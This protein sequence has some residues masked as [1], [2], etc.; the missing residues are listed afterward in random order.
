MSYIDKPCSNCCQFLVTTGRDGII[1]YYR[2]DHVLTVVGF[3]VNICGSMVLIGLRF[4]AKGDMF[5]DVGD[6]HGLSKACV[7][8][9]FERFI[10]AVNNKLDNIRNKRHKDCFLQKKCKIPN[11]LGATDGTLI[12]I[13][14][15]KEHEETFVCRKG[16]HALNVQ[17]V[18]DQKMRFTDIVT[19]WPGS[20]HDAS[21]FDSCGLK[22]YLENG[23]IS[24]HLGD[25]GYPLRK[26]LIT[27]KLNPVT[28]AEMR[29]SRAHFNGRIIVERTFGVLKSRFRCLH[30]TGG[31]LQFTPGKCAN[32]I[33]ACMRL[34]NMCIDRNIPL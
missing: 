17:A 9:S 18:V 30:K 14:A 27:P 10:N 5:S 2:L 29:Y 23:Q 12:P 21:I 8:T 15:P 31:C 20:Q 24:G 3:G 7:S 11:V 6:L 22:Q 19:K 1:Q 25:S 26:Y 16:F 34:H 28:E 4:L 32:V 33:S 13:L